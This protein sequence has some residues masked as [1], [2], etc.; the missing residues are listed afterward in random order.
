MAGKSSGLIDIM[1][2]IVYNVVKREGYAVELEENN[3]ALEVGEGVYTG[4]RPLKALREI[5]GELWLKS[6]CRSRDV[7]AKIA[8][9]VPRTHRAS[10]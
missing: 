10:F 8:S 3:G 5:S 7:I 2:Y 4:D 9:R 6:T 1:C